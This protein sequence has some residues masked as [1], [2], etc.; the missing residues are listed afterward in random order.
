MH[1]EETKRKISLAKKGKPIV[2]INGHADIKGEKN[3]FY[4]KRHSE[5]TKAKISLANKGNTFCIGRVMSEKTKAIIS[6]K[7]KERFALGLQCLGSGPTQSARIIISEKA[8]KRFSDPRNHPFWG[9]RLNQAQKAKLSRLGWK[10]SEESKHRISVASRLNWLNPDY[11][12]RA[13]SSMKPNKM[14]LEV[15]NLLKELSL[16]Y[17]YVGDGQFIVGGKCPD[18]LNVNGQKKLIEF[19]GHHWHQGEN[20]QA[21]IAHFAQYGFHTLII[22]EDELKRLGELKQKLLRFNSKNSRVRVLRSKNTWTKLR[23][24]DANISR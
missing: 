13:L 9:R 10:H 11:A 7:A 5:E 12:R 2:Y 16:P 15:D 17:R 24:L 20:P 6:A 21:R 18:F 22:W 23:C 4:G 1:T 8:K 3:P 14:E 19:Y